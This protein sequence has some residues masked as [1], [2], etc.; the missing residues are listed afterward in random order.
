[1]PTATKKDLEHIAEATL[2]IKLYFAPKEVD[3]IVRDK[4]RDPFGPFAK[5]YDFRYKSPKG[6]AASRAFYKTEEML[7]YVKRLCNSKHKATTQDVTPDEWAR[8]KEIRK[9]IEALDETHVYT[10]Y[11]HVRGK[12]GFTKIG[13]ERRPFVFGGV[14]DGQFSQGTRTFTNLDDLEAFVD[15]YLPRCITKEQNNKINE[16]NDL[17]RKKKV[18][19]RFDFQHGPNDTTFVYLPYGEDEKVEGLTYEGMRKLARKMAAEATS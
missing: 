1:M 2:M 16:L 10:G 18:N 11:I 6:K 8:I 15:D 5:L 13:N 9:R 12:T 17:M 3:L 7:S 19:G 4:E 14:S